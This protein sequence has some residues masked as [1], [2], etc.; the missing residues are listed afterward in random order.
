MRLFVRVRHGDRKIL[1]TPDG[2]D[3]YTPEPMENN[4]A[5]MDVMKQIARK[6]SVNSSNVR[7]VSGS[8]SR[9]KIIDVEK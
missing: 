4:R 9:K 6:Y 1:E 8:R 7:I 3:V 5:N 2:L